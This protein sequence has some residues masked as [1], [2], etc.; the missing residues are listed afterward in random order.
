MYVYTI[1]SMH[2]SIKIDELGLRNERKNCVHGMQIY[3][4]MRHVCTVTIPRVFI[5]IHVYV[6]IVDMT[7]AMILNL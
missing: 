3:M 6:C 7:F 1:C 2:N 5:T 4:T